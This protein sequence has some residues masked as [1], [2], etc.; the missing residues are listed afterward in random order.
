MAVVLID[1]DLPDFHDSFAWEG[2]EST[3]QQAFHVPYVNAELRSTIFWPST[4]TY[5][6]VHPGQQ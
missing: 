5:G 4:R 1:F 2:D 3:A 6:H